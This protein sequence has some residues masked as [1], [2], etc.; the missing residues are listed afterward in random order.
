MLPPEGEPQGMNPDAYP[1]LQKSLALLITMSMSP[2]LELEPGTMHDFAES[3][4][5]T[6]VPLSTPCDKSC[7][8]S[9]FQV[10]LEI[11]LRN[12]W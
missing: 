10:V 6:A 7:L 3:K 11:H 4:H 9:R 1:V 5:K 2:P 12:Y 8:E